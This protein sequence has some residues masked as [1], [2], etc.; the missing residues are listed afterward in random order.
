MQKFDDLVLGAGM[1]GLACAALLAK[2]GRRVG[3]LE[4]HDVPGGYAHSFAVRGY[5]F[6]AQV[7]YIFGCG[8]GEGVHSLLSELGVAERVPFVRLDPE[9]FDHVLVAGERFRIPNGLA[10]HRDRLVRRFPEARQPLARYFDLVRKIS[11]ELSELERLPEKLTLGFV[12]RNAWRFRHLA[13]HRTWTLEELYDRIFMPPLL[14]AILAG[15]SGDY[16]LPPRDVSLL[17]HVALVAGYDSGAYYP[18]HHYHHLVETL[19][20]VVREAPGCRLLLEHE[21]ERIEVAGGR[22]AEIVT[23]HGERFTAERIISNIDPRRTAQLVGLEHFDGADRKRLRYDYSA[24]TFTM[25]LGVKGLDLR[26][27]GFGSF[28]V[29]RYPHADLNRI[30]D[31]QLRAHDLSDPWLFLSTPTLHSPEPGI[32]PPGHQILEVATALDFQRW[33]ALRERDRR[34]YY[35]EKNALRDRI[36][37]ILEAELVP[38]LRRHLT[39]RLTGTGATNERF[40]RAPEGHS[41]GARL[42]PA[43]VHAGRRPFRSSVPNLWMVGATAGFPSVAGALGAGHAL[44]RELLSDAG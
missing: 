30:Y 42:T 1:G 40:C 24:A 29:W 11:D 15:Q 38:D 44:A 20:D 6:C 4:A 31:A 25:Y 33:K 35:R 8:E 41:Y 3:V 23:R 26:E 12:V 9:G 10:K 22:V 14:R 18:K 32:A 19:A 36:L 5:R 17:L 27:H 16:L 21:V 28:N 39:L 13:L 43:H 7:H 37:D 2:R 34:G